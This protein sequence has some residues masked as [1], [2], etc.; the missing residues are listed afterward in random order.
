MEER[1]GEQ[2]VL[3][4]SIR[5]KTCGE[6]QCAFRG[7]AFSQCLPVFLR[8]PHPLLNFSEHILPPLMSFIL[9]AL[10]TQ[11]SLFLVSP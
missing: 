6:K 9:P 3:A 4:N 11:E 2:R 7:L 10:F 8:V 5:A 1:V